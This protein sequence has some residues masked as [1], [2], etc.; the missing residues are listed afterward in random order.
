MNKYDDMIKMQYRGVKNHRHM[1][2][3]ERAIQFAPFAAL[4]GFK[5][6]IE[7][8]SRIREDRVYLEED[9]I[10]NIDEKLKYLKNNLMKKVKITYFSQIYNEKGVYKTIIGIIKNI[11]EINQYIVFENNVRINFTDIFELNVL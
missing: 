2:L 8:A 9:A 11:D 5:E 6:E 4:N 1:T 7:N 3:E 10:K